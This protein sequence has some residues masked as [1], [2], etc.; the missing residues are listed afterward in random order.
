MIIVGVWETLRGA[1]HLH[2][3]PQISDPMYRATTETVANRTEAVANSSVHCFHPTHRANA[4]AQSSAVNTE[5]QV[6]IRNL[7]KKK[8]TFL[9]QHPKRLSCSVWNQNVILRPLFLGHV[10]REG[11]GRVNELLLSIFI[12][13]GASYY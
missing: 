12:T 11:A 8:K 9:K 13:S 5:S 10:P 7:E 2:I 1:A 6:Q 4:N 3:S